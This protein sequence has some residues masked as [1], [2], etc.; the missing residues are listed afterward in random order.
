MNEQR[1]LNARYQPIKLA[2]HI[3]GLSVYHLRRLHA[4]GKLPHIMSGSKIMVDMM[5]LQDLLDKGAET[6]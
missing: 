4:A 5:K 3:T 2:A 1:N 6:A